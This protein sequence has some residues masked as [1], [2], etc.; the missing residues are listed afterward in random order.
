MDRLIRQA[1][2]ALFGLHQQD[3]RL[4]RRSTTAGFGIIWKSAGKRLETKARSRAVVQGRSCCC[5]RKMAAIRPS[6]GGR[7]TDGKNGALVEVISA[8]DKCKNRDDQS[9]NEDQQSRIGSWVTLKDHIDHVCSEVQSLSECLDL[10]QNYRN[11]LKNAAYW[12]DVGKVHPAFQNMLLAGKSDGES[13][14]EGGPWAKSKGN[15]GRARYWVESSDGRV[16]ERRYFR[17]ELASALAWLQ[18]QGK[19]E[20]MRIW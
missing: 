5:I 10:P 12:H 6:W 2:R 14:R 17:H 8:K 4:S 9:M 18:T 7:E 13:R 1:R 20:K 16:I 11:A 19:M 15:N 3:E